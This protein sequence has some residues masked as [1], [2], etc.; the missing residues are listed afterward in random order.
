MLISSD[1]SETCWLCDHERGESCHVH[2]Q[3]TRDD[4]RDEPETT[5]TVATPEAD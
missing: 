4:G 2:E 3:L 5:W 1:T